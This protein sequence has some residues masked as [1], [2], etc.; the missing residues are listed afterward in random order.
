MTITIKLAQESCGTLATP[1]KMPGKAIG[2]TATH[3]ITGSKLR[4]IPGSVCFDCYALKNLY[5]QP[6]VVNAL[7]NR[8]E[9]VMASQDDK[10][11]WINGMVKLIWNQEWFRWDDSGDL[12][13]VFHLANICEVA[14]RTPHVNHWLPSREYRMIN[15]YEANGGI[16]PSNLVIR[17][18]AHMVDAPPPVTNRPTSTVVTDGSQTCPARSQNNECGTCRACWD[19]NVKNVSY[20]KH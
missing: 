7:E 6:V 12:Q 16:I 19:P 3:C 4:L 11:P 17:D 13:G 9:K 2:T 15:D 20:P 5:T 1:S 18:S 14:K 8:W 10:W